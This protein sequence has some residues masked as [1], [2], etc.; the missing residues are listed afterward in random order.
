MGSWA[1]RLHLSLLSVTSHQ[2]KDNKM[3]YSKTTNQFYPEEFSYP[4]IPAD[5]ITITDSE[6]AVAMN[7][8]PDEEF[9]VVAGKV[10]TEKKFTPTTEIIA[11]MW[12][13]IKASRELRENGGFKVEISKGV[14]KWF[15]SDPGSRVQWLGMVLAGAVLPKIPWK[16]MD[17][18]FVDTT[19]ALAM[20]VFQQAFTLDTTLFSVA[21]NHKKK[22]E[23]SQDPSA[24]DFSDGWPEHYAV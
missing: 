17:G 10:V 11:G 13:Q 2:H 1:V 7:R 23:N 22:M 15:H 4:D 14:F 24:Y 20:Q 8:K 6:F 19:P 21:E 5:V 16:T 9:K 3:R 12:A 18:T